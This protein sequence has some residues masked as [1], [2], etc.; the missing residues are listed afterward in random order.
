MARGGPRNADG[1]SKKGSRATVTLLTG[2]GV[3]EVP[4]MP[5][6]E[7]WIRI[8]PTIQT[9]K[10]GHNDTAVLKAAG[11]DTNP[12]PDRFTEDE[13]TPEWSPAVVR[14]WH[15]IWGSPMASEFVKA[16]IHGL[17][18]G[19]YYLHESL[20]PFYK[21]TDRVNAAKAFENTIK[22]YGLTPSARES[23]RWN[24][25]QG[26]AAQKR[27]DQIR[28]SSSA[29]KKTGKDDVTDMYKRHG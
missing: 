23:L 5:P 27:T 22:N 9:D 17:Y 29:G 2:E 11:V 1:P 19:C 16:D 7:D 8:P 12:D 10:R 15:D 3:S 28:A 6:A 14:W 21:L 25:S 4:P 18:L 20:N 26:M 24:I 13:L